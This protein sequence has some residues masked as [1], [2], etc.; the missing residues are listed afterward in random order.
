MDDNMTT[1]VNAG[2]NPRNN[3]FTFLRVIGLN[4]TKEIR[5]ELLRIRE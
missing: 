1:M 5:L 2:T 3:K 4:E